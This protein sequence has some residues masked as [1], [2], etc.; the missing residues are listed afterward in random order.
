M[1]IK[2][3]QKIYERKVKIYFKYERLL[4][5]ERTLEFKK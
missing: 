1:E 2:L 4:F 3:I 5:N